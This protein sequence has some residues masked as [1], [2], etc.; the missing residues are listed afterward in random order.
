M[1]CHSGLKR[2]CIN[3][4]CCVCVGEGRG[5]CWSTHLSPTWPPP[6]PLVTLTFGSLATAVWMHSMCWEKFNWIISLSIHWELLKKIMKFSWF[7][8]VDLQL[9]IT[10]CIR[11]CQLEIHT[12][13]TRLLDRSTGEVNY[14]VTSKHGQM[15]SDIH[16]SSKC[17]LGHH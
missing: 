1:N 7:K 5:R 14:K 15:S 13:Y 6:L 12:Y 17:I 3:R 11:K 8:T 4:V 2:K 9:A 16:F 10:H